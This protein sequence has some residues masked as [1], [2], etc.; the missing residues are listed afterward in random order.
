MPSKPK[1][2]IAKATKR[3]GALH[4]ALGV[5]KDKK[6]PAMKLAKAEHSKN[7]RIKKEANLA[8]T[9]RGLRK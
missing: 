4:A 2:W 8:K 7:P 6:I 9:L 3:P 1:H 5:D